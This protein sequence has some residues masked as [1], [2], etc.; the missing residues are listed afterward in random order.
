MGSGIPSS[1]RRRHRPQHGL[2]DP[3][4]RARHSV[5]GRRPIRAL[6]ALRALSPDVQAGTVNVECLPDGQAIR[7]EISYDL[8][9]LRATT[10]G[11]LQQFADGYDTPHRMG[12]SHR[13]RAGARTAPGRY[14][15]TTTPRCS[16]PLPASLP[17]GH[18]HG[19]ERVVDWYRNRSGSVRSI[20]A[21]ARQLRPT[22]DAPVCAGPSSRS[23]VVSC[24]C[25]VR[26]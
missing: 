11:A 5:G 22:P 3:C 6:D 10:E 18:A 23:D 15:R 7:A 17:R 25:S 8:T 2:R 26:P 19:T 21:P 20:G 1:A 24:E 14:L 9:T 12:A 16:S 4:P 13:R